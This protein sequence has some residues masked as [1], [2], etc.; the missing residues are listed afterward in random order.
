MNAGAWGKHIGEYVESVDVLDRTGRQRLLEGRVLAW[1]Y[2]RSGLEKYI[3]YRVRVRL[4]PKD[5]AVSEE[6]AGSFM[7]QRLERQDTASRSAGCVF[8][9]PESAAAG[10]LI[11]DCGLK[12]RRVGGAVVSDKHANFIVNSGHATAADVMKLMALVRRA[13]KRSSGIALRNEIKIWK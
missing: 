13:V 5:P 12:G 6:E 8:R 4:V 7:R 9:N 3:V 2:R 10:R 1:G 11:E